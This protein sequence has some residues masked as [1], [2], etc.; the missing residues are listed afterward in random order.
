MLGIAVALSFSIT[1]MHMP[2]LGA[3]LRK[4]LMPVWSLQGLPASFALPAAGSFLERLRCAEVDQATSS[5]LMRLVRILSTSYENLDSREARDILRESR[6]PNL[7]E[8]PP[9]GGEEE[10]MEQLCF[11]LFKYLR[12]KMHPSNAL[13]S[14]GPSSFDE[15][16][17]Q[18]NL[19]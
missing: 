17:H 19:P 13:V 9:S 11:H 4:V 1:T 8:W 3:L 12:L 16:S 7:P 18:T 6:G 2:F 15:V 10:R 14:V 5:T